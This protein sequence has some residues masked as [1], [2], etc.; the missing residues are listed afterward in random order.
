MEL[1]PREGSVPASS[2]SPGCPLPAPGSPELRV[3]A[4]V[5]SAGPRPAAALHVPARLERMQRAR[6]RRL[7]GATEDAGGR[8]VAPGDVPM[9]IPGA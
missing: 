6:L 8:I 5:L 9:L 4:P 2:R 7:G 1:W 3:P